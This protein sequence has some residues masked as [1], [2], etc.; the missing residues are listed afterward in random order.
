M[1]FQLSTLFV[2]LAACG[3]ELLGSYAVFD[4]VFARSAAP[5]PGGSGRT[6][7]P[8]MVFADV[9]GARIGEGPNR[10]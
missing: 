5:P 7:D 9:L 1:R 4:R 6:P 3:G 2:V 10:A 8:A